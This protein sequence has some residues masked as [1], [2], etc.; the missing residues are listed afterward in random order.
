MT[1]SLPPRVQSITVPEQKLYNGKPFP[2]ILSPVSPFENKADFLAWIKESTEILK[3]LLLE[4]GAIAFRGFDIPSA[5]EFSEMLESI[6]L[7]P[8]PYIGGAA[9]RTL[10]VG[11]VQTANEAPPSEKIPFHH[12]MAQVPSY[13]RNIFFYCLTPAKTGGQTPLVS[14]AVVASRLRESNPKFMKDL[15]EKGVVYTRV[16]PSVDDPASPIGRSWPS[17]F[18]SKE[19]FVAESN[20]KN[21]GVNLTW[22]ENGDCKSVSSVTKAVRKHPINGKEVFFNSVVAAYVGWHDSRNNR[23]DAVKVGFVL[24]LVWRWKPS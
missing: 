4:Y 8:F 10:V 6:N 20:A 19:K 11:N 12:E 13:P 23:L 2:L 21:L 7:E 14:S 3:S 9:P 22:L 18:G 15:D 16:L 1:I 24:I 17:T 5:N